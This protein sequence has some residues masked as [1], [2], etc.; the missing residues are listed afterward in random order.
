MGI[1]DGKLD[2]VLNTFEINASTQY[3]FFSFILQKLPQQEKTK[4]KKLNFQ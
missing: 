4:R 3:F 1:I 2:I